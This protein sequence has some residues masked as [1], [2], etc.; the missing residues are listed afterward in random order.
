[1]RTGRF[2]RRSRR[3]ALA[4]EYAA[5]LYLL[6][7]FLAFPMINFATVGMRT[8]FLWF[9]CDQAVIT[10]AKCRTF[11]TPVTIGNTLYPGAYAMAQARANQ[12]RSTFPGIHWQNS[13]TNP[14]VD[15]IITQIPGQPASSPAPPTKTVGPGPGPGL[16]LGNTPDVN[17][18][19]PS[20]RVTIKGWV[21]PLVPVP[22][23]KIQGLTT[24]MFLNVTC[25]QEFENPPGLQI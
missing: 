14:E 2:L 11:F 17:S 18:Y 25:Q 13:P 24:S 1:M 8:F 22:L 15:I 20:I 4:A 9:A 21:D 19:V 3:G 23:F 10:A 7:F 6:F 12:I 5:S 16:G